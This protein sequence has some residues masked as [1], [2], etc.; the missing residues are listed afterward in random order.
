MEVEVIE[1]PFDKCEIDL[2]YLRARSS[3]EQDS[4]GAAKSRKRDY[5]CLNSY[6]GT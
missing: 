6:L 2:G 1:W 5:E 3:R 4:A